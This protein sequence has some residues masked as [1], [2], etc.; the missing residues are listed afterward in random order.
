[1]PDDD[2]ELEDD[3]VDIDVLD[4]EDDDELRDKEVRTD[5]LEDV[6]RDVFE[7]EELFDEEDGKEEDFEL[8]DTTTP[9]R[10]PLT[11]GFSAVL[12]PLFP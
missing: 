6:D 7:L 4:D 8:L 5:V 1:M 11:I 9:H 2:F 12:V 3:E 10:V